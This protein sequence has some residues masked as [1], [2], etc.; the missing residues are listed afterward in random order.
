MPVGGPLVVRG[1]PKQSWARS[2]GQVLFQMPWLLTEKEWVISPVVS[3]RSY[4]SR[5]AQQLTQNPSGGATARSSAHT[6]SSGPYGHQQLYL[7]GKA[8]SKV[9]GAGAGFVGLQPQH[10]CGGQLVMGGA[11]TGFFLGDETEIRTLQATLS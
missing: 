4:P 1:H 11:A 7:S 2:G 3:S 9:H 10:H 5:A 6:V 8:A